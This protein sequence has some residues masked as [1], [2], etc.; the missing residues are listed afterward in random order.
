ML[1]TGACQFSLSV[2]GSAGTKQVSHWDN[3]R[4]NVEYAFIIDNQ[5]RHVNLG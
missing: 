2:Q 4:E 1:I 3:F 5:H